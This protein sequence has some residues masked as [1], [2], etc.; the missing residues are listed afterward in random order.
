[1]N[2]VIGRR[3]RRHSLLE[4]STDPV[5]VVRAMCGAHA[6]VMSAAELSIGLR[7]TL[8]RQ[9]VR[10]AVW[11]DRTL[12][13]TRGPRGTV[14]LLPAADLPM[15]TGALSR[16]PHRSRLLTEEQSEQVVAA[17]A[18]ALRDAELT[19]DELTG[20]VVART[21]PWAGERV[22][23]AFGGTPWPRWVEAMGTA[24]NRGAMCFAPNKG[25]K[26][27]YTSPQR[28]SPGFTP[29][30][31]GDVELLHAY[32]R[33]YGPATPAH[34]ARWLAAPKRWVDGVF[35]RADVE[36]VEGGWV[37]RGDTAWPDEPPG[38]VRLLP[39]FDAY[40]VGSHPREVVFPGRAYERALSGGQAG[41]FP[42]VLVDGL[43]AGV[44]HQKRSGRRIVVTVELFKALSRARSA[45]LER[46]VVRLG[47]FL[48]GRPEL[49]VGPVSVGGHA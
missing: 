1:M 27:A 21:G 22:M 35:A 24:S 2:P 5:A 44:W 15:W 42:V 46:E 20:E 4:P 13:K 19:G 45:E 12:V 31:A 25:R 32:L 10:D 18:E 33:S 9:Q 36:Q 14:H 43:V 16:L 38:G 48:E 47:G 17:I 29:D 3:L 30:E 34:F 39:Y 23:E 26:T 11:V 41:N 37:V 40:V 8:T 49:T 28:W 6:Q 7:T